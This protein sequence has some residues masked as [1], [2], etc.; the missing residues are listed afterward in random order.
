MVLVID[1]QGTAR[2]LYSEVLD[3]A[4]LGSLVISRAS[5]V[6]PDE[7]GLWWADLSPVDGPALGPF[8]L[9]S[10]ALVAE[11]TWLDNRLCTAGLPSHGPDGHRGPAANVHPSQTRP[12]RDGP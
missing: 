7:A 6:E 10:E 9:R 11:S 3:L 12:A 8:P 4:G 5:H 2:C 1:I